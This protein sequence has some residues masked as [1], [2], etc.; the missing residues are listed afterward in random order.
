MAN[1]SSPPIIF[2]NIKFWKNFCAL[3][4]VCYEVSFGIAFRQF[5]IFF[6][7]ISCEPTVGQKGQEAKRAEVQKGPKVKRRNI[8]VKDGRRTRTT[9]R[10]VKVAPRVAPP[11]G[12]QPK[13]DFQAVSKIVLSSKRTD[14]DVLASDKNICLGQK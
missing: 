8:R 11:S 3:S 6:S 1:F 10:R 13:T 9:T 2:F 5:E 4:Q 12:R 7:M 14:H